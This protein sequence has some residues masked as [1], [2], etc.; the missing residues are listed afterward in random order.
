MKERERDGQRRRRRR[1]RERGKGLERR[2]PE[3]AICSAVARGNVIN[4]FPSSLELACRVHP[5]R[6]T[7]T[8]GYGHT[9][10]R[11]TE[12]GKH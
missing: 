2:N 4:T 7:H 10:T 9:H 11:S 3:P 12:M 1:E 5:L 8:D 6:I